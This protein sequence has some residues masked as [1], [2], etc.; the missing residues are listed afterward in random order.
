MKIRVSKTANF[1]KKIISSLKARLEGPRRFANR[2]LDWFTGKKTILNAFAPV[3]SE[4][5]STLKVS[6]MPKLMRNAKQ[7]FIRRHIQNM[8]IY[9]LD[10]IHR[11]RNW[12][13][14]SNKLLDARRNVIV[15]YKNFFRKRRR[16]L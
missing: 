15:R 12:R 13:E 5:L 1:S 3:S 2:M 16:S 11:G 14:I 7:N 6:I 10:L 8:P 4:N 9:R